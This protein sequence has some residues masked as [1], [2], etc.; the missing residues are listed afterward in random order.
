MRT[1]SCVLWYRTWKSWA[2][3]KT[4]SEAGASNA[5]ESV[6]YLRRFRVQGAGFRVQDSGFRVQGS[7]FRVQGGGCRVPGSGFRMPS[8]E[9]ASKAS[10]SVAYLHRWWD[11]LRTSHSENSWTE[12]C[13]ERYSSQLQDKCVSQMW[14][15]SEEG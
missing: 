5:S 1:I 10:E 14:S 3:A 9:G 6:A 4:P 13:T 11:R 15:G 8:V 2:T 7:G 12:S